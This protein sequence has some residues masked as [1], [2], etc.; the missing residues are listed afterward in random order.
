MRY[1]EVKK[2]N[3][4]KIRKHAHT[5]FIRINETHMGQFNECANRRKITKCGKKIT[6]EFTMSF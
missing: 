6:L 1:V 2:K 5:T 4:D 3:C